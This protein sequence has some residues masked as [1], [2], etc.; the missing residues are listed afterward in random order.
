MVSG[1]TSSSD[2]NNDTQG[3]GDVTKRQVYGGWVAETPDVH[4]S[5]LPL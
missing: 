3:G 4:Y 2:L 1:E 5:S